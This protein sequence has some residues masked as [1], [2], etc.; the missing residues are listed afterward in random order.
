MDR[1]GLAGRR[2]GPGNALRDGEVDLEGAGAVTESAVGAGDPARQPIAEDV[3]GDR[4]RHV[5]H[6]HIARREVAGRGH[7]LTGLDLAAV[8]FD[9]G[10]QRVGDRLRAAFGHHPPLGV[11]GDDQHQPDGAGH[12]TVEA[13]AGM[14][15]DAGPQRPDLLRP[16]E[17]S[18]RGG[19]QHRGGAEARQHQRMSRHAQDRLGGVGE[20]VV[21]PRDHRREDPTPSLTVPPHPVGGPLDRSVQH[22][23]RSV[24]ER[25]GTV[26]R[27]LQPGQAVRGEVQ[28]GRGTATRRRSDGM[29]S[30]D[31]ARD[32]GRSSP[33][34]VSHHRSCRWPRARSRRGRREPAAPRRRARSA[35]CRRRSP[36][37]RC[38]GLAGARTHTRP[39]VPG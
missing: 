24:V 14:R 32:R 26:D 28:P 4:R 2:R 12:R 38:H 3:G 36:S 10:G 8:A 6:Q 20:Q 31:R 23:G 17:P 11:S 29:P 16:P 19:R 18:Q 35:R 37:S 9:V 39:P 21:E 13:I 34:C 33:S 5:Q 22:T 25:M 27:R 15:R 1:A 7:E 30:S